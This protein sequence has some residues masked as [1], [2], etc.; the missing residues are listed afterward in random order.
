MVGLRD[1]FLYIGFGL[2]F[3]RDGGEEVENGREEEMRKMGLGL[4]LVRSLK[5]GLLVLGVSFF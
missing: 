4:G 2:W 1:G 5:M 3:E